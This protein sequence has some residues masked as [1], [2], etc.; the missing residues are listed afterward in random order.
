MARHQMVFVD[1]DTQADFMLPAGR[2]YVPGAEKLIP[3]IERLRDFAE[4]R[5]IPVLASTD[6]HATDDPEFRTWPPH[7]VR[8]TPGQLKVPESLFTQYLVVPKERLSPLTEQELS[9]YHQWILEKDDLDLFTNP[10]ADDL[11]NRLSPAAY[12]VYGVATEFCVRLGVLGLR[13]RERRVLLLTDAIQG[14]DAAGTAKAL[15]EM[16][17]AGA[18][19]ATS[20]DVLAAAA[21]A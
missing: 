3:T 4:R 11:M 18:E 10:Q 13:K 15:H 7:C 12:V 8:G 9:R 6:A 16:R 5:G 2:L 19:L 21:M 14:I 1:V 17:E 20:Q